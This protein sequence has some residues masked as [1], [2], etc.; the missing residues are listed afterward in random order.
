MAGNI[1]KAGKLVVVGG[2]IIYFVGTFAGPASTASFV[3]KS[4]HGTAW[5]V[6]ILGGA[7]PEIGPGFQEGMSASKVAVKP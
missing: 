3:T 1:Y 5:G 2:V 7:A 4:V 6:G